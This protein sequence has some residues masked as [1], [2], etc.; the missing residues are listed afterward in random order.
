ML[1]NVEIRVKAGDGGNGAV[2]FRRQK[3]LACGGPDGGDGGKGGDVIIKADES[4]TTLNYFHNN[5]LYKAE[6]AGHGQNQKKY[7]KGGANLCL[8]VPVGTIIQ[9]YDNSGELLV[10][11]DLD[12]NQKEVVVAKGG[13]GGLGNAR[14]ASATNQTPRLAEKGVVGEAKDIILELR[15]L[16]DVGIIGYPNVGK[17]SLLGMA[18]AANPK[19]GDYAFTTMS[20]ILGVVESTSERF[21]MCEIP[22]LIDGAHLGKGLGHSFLRHAMRTRVLIH[23]LD[24]SSDSPI[25]DMIAI[26]NEL[27]LYDIDL[28]NKPQ[29]VVIN[30]IDK[31]EVG[32]RKTELSEMFHSAGVT[33]FFIS[34]ATGDGVKEVLQEVLE[35]LRQNPITIRAK[36]LQEVQPRAIKP[37]LSVKETEGVF[38]ISSPGLERLVSGS[39][40]KDPEVRRQIAGRI[41]S[42]RL[43]HV[44]ESAGI[45]TGDKIR[46]ADFEWIW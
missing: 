5:K 41:T 22:G 19:I 37:G 32:E 14:F 28:A 40:I 13:Q 1:D 10:L 29:V 21:V 26:R 15:I 16:A 44:I 30:K 8:L 27:Y 35:L 31:P 17:S 4:I 12:Q 7:G 11:A 25:D 20:P 24:G 3:F 9:T 36:E 34:A 2:S 45:K 18:T 39:D 33:P 42:P 46:I 23:L 43:R 38:V 6:N